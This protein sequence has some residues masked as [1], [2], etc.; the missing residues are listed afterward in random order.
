M[1]YLLFALLALR[2]TAADLVWDD[3]NPQGTVSKYKVWAANSSDIWSVIATVNTNRWTIVLPAGA[4]KLAVSAVGGNET[5][6][7]DLSQTKIVIVLIQPT[8]P[9]IEQ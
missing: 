8:T 6:E 4:H 9:R 7:S 2:T 5:I 1:R 3:P